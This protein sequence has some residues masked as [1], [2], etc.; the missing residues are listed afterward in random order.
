MHKKTSILLTAMVLLIPTIATG[1][2]AEVPN[3]KGELFYISLDI[4]GGSITGSGT[5][6]GMVNI[7]GCTTC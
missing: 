2:D 7:E 4:A 1:Q 3:K 5:L 6:D